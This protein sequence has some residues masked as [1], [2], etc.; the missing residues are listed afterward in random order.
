MDF[1]S[2]LLFLRLFLHA[3]AGF[4]VATYRPDQMTRHRSGVSIIAAC[5]AGTC[6]ALSAWILT[7]WGKECQGPQVWLTMLAAFVFAAVAFTGGNIAKL[8]PRLKWDVHS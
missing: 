6:F 5:F 1:D 2:V 7:N 4:I 3:G 8:L